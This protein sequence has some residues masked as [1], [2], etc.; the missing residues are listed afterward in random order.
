MQD[1][2]SPLQYWIRS[3]T[4]VFIWNPEIA[5][6][7][8]VKVQ[9]PSC[10]SITVI[11]RTMWTDSI[12]PSVSDESISGIWNTY[13]TISAILCFKI[14]LTNVHKNSSIFKTEYLK[15]VKCWI[16]RPSQNISNIVNKISVDEH[17]YIVKYVYW[18]LFGRRW[19]LEKQATV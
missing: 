19:Y 13:Y 10:Y 7:G 1:V 8:L 16:Q 4:V 3:P 14:N 15:V 17:V 12:S 2:H 5:L 11:D 18:H 6:S 9:C